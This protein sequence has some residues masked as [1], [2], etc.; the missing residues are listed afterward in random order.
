MS[1]S[2]EFFNKHGW[3]KIESFI[4][5]ETANFFYTYVKLAAKRLLYVEENIEDYNKLKYYKEFYGTFEDS[6][7]PNAYSKYGDLVFDTLLATSCNCIGELIGKKLL[8]TYS[9]HR[10]YVEDNI[11]EKHKDRESCKLSS[12]LCLG[13]DI[14]NIDKNVYPN[15][16]W[17]I[18][19]KENDGTEIPISLNPGDM[20]IYK[21]AE[22]EHWREKYIGN[23]HAQV[24]LH[25]NDEN[26][27]DKIKYDNRPELGLPQDI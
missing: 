27:L 6:Q 14:T 18:W 24:F 2:A 11:L 15:Y 10:L 19:V 20:L 1:A 17:A 21:G 3:L 4:P 25:Y 16:N 12:T 9:Y 8:P 22:V 13:Y 5:P 26:D 23:N 7:A